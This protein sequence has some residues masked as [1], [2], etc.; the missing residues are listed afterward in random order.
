MIGTGYTNPMAKRKKFTASDGKMVLELE[1]TDDGWLI[2][3][4]PLDPA[5]LTQAR[6]IVE[7]FE[8]AYDA[9]ETLR[10]GR[11]QLARERRKAKA[12]A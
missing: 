8:M 10:Q 3:S 7:A 4:S 2:V 5:L 12:T 9:A 11:R 6:S 1:P